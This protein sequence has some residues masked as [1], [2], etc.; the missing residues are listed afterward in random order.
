[1][2]ILLAAILDSSDFICCLNQELWWFGSVM[3]S[4]LLIIWQTNY[5]LS[6]Q[7]W[8]NQILW[9][10]N[11]APISRLF[12][13]VAWDHR[14]PSRRNRCCALRVFA[15]IHAAAWRSCVLGPVAKASLRRC[16]VR[17]GHE[18][19]QVESYQYHFISYHHI[20]FVILCTVHITV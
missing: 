18:I 8:S 20:K 19:V 10:K 4:H 7:T 5:F 17:F 14:S 15:V 6:N 13:F 9:A 16:R 2:E 11:G 12:S 3:M 1:M